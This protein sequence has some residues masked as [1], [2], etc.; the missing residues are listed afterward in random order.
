MTQK[1]TQV[2]DGHNPFHVKPS[3]ETRVCAIC[4]RHR[5]IS[6]FGTQGPKEERRYLQTCQLCRQTRVRARKKY[7]LTDQK[8]QWEKT[9]AKLSLPQNIRARTKRMWNAAR[10]RAWRYGIDFSLPVE[11]ISSRL[12]DGR[13]EVT[14]LQ[15]DF[16]HPGDRR[17]IFGPS[18]DRRD[19]DGGYTAENCR[20]VLLC[21]NLAKGR[22]TH[23]AVVRFA[24]G[25]VAKE[26]A[27]LEQKATRAA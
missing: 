13:C 9:A 12:A 4:K 21:Y 1:L 8:T 22:G 23:E 27:E 17:N 7:K 19:P 26:E 14:G 10:L 15:F 6:L 11:W 5:H 18:I 24:C 16:S 25:L 2:I 20:M 3:S